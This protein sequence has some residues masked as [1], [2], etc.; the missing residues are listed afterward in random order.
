MIGPGNTH[1]YQQVE[2]LYWTGVEQELENIIRT[3]RCWQTSENSD[4]HIDDESDDYIHG[5]DTF[6]GQVSS[7]QR[8]FA[9]RYG[10][11]FP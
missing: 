6:L 10:L 11:C 7:E 9:K 1:L 3:L 8:A 5:Y 2:S 4:V